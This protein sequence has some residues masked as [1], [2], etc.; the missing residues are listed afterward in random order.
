MFIHRLALA[1]GKTV[2]ELLAS[3]SLEELRDWQ[4]FDRQAGLPDLAAQWQR[5]VAISVAGAA[6]GSILD[7]S[8]YIPL[9]AWD[10]KPATAQQIK[11]VFSHGIQ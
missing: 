10:A 1:L 11:E 5:G 8:E 7:A 4:Q 6:A 2:S 3:L 9:I